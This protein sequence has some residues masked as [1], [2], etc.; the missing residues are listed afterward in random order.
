MY[1]WCAHGPISCQLMRA[2]LN[3]TSA[4]ELRNE[5]RLVWCGDCVSLVRSLDPSG[6]QISGF[7]SSED[8]IFCPFWQFL[9]PPFQG[10]VRHIPVKKNLSAPPPGACTHPRPR[11]SEMHPKRRNLRNQICNPKWRNTREKLY[12]KCREHGN[13]LTLIPLVAWTGKTTNLIP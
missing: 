3:A 10:F 2:W 5:A 12:P 11:T 9:R 6:L 1:E 7:L 8:P 13:L 4:S